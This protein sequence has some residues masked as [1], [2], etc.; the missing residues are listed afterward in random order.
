M[1]N[2]INNFFTVDWEDWYHANFREVNKQTNIQT[3]IIVNSTN[4][5]LNI[6][7]QTKTKATF[8][9]LTSLATKYPELIREIYAKG[10]EIASHGHNHELVYSIGEKL[11]EKDLMLSKKII[12]DITGKEPIGYRAPS[13]SVSKSQT[14]WFWKILHKHGFKY[15]SSVMP[16]KTH[17]YGD[18]KSDTNPH[19]VDHVLEIPC[20]TCNMFNQKIPFSGGFYLRLFPLYLINKFASINNNNHTLNVFYIHP[21][22]MYSLHPKIKLNILNNF[23]HYHNLNSTPDKVVSILKNFKCQSIGEHYFKDNS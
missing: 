11:F 7:D 8:F 2:K 20:T 13:W 16:F 14:P 19:I 15:S 6:L 17:L 22:E 1:V 10:H 5:I 18:S 23:I 12:L 3:S 9:V 4:K 21:R